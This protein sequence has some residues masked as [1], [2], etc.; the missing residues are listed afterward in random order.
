[1]STRGALGFRRNGKDLIAYNHSDS[2][3]DWLG[4][5]VLE[6]LAAHGPA[7]MAA[8]AD[9]LVMVDESGTATEQEIMDHMDSLN[10]GVSTGA[11][12]EYYSLLRGAQG[13]LAYYDDPKHYA[14]IDGSGFL[15][16]SLFCEWAYVI[17]LDEGTLEVYKGFNRSPGGAGRYAAL[18]DRDYWGVTLMQAYPL[19][20]LPAAD[21]FV[22]ELEAGDE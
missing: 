3:P 15:A 4:R 20:S 12:T 7:Q 21:A 8:V 22:A 9:K 2:Y 11:A 14:M 19:S 18:Q 16:D 10:T 13:D 17:N 5:R 6:Y 1:M